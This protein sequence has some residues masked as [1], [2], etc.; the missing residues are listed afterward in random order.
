[1]GL[2]KVITEDTVFI[3]GAGASAPYGYPTG[4]ELRRLIIEEFPKRAAHD[5][6]VKRGPLGND[7]IWMERVKEEITYDAEN[8]SEIFE[9]SRTS[10]ID[11]FLSRRRQFYE[12]GRRAIAQIIFEKEKN[13]KFEYEMDDVSQDWYKY[14]Y[15]RMTETLVDPESYMGF[16]D[17]NVTFITFNYDRSLE[18]FLYDAL[19]HS[20]EIPLGG[21]K[22][23]DLFPF[24]FI[25]VYGKLADLDWQESSGV[26]YGSYFIPKMIENINIIY[27]SENSAR[28]QKTLKERIT[29]AKR[30]FFLG[31][32]F[33]PENMEIL[34]IPE[35][36]KSEP[37]I[38]GTAFNW[39]EK[40]ILNPKLVRR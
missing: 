26:K 11:L 29:N 23:K 33:A 31:F 28:L 35:V 15:R 24:E 7:K 12:I 25:H 39:T 9:K 21:I 4:Y 30:I 13:S 34:G 6:F 37:Q 40:E 27:D 5:E 2:R 1:V 16:A 20:F 10:S 32:G 36:L 38:Y 14:L 18:H 3:L 22:T 8:L 19:I 17:N